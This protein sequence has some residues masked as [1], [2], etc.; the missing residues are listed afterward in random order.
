LLEWLRYTGRFDIHASIIVYAETLLWYK[1]L[2]LTREELEDE[3]RKLKASIKN[4]DE[5]LADMAT[6]SALKYGGSFPFKDHARDYVIGATALDQ[7]A[8]LITYNTQHFEW[9]AKEGIAVKTPEDF[10]AENL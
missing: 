4:L 7:K 9:L 10:V 2:G 3:L 5:R 1:T 6:D 8:T